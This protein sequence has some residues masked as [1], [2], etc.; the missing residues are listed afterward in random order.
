ML[1]SR[2]RSPISP[3]EGAQ[4]SNLRWRP[5]GLGMMGLQDAFSNC[6]YAFDS[7]DARKLSK[8]R[9]RSTTTRSPLRVSQRKRALIEFP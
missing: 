6:S 9:K 2:D 4:D 8:S 5:V 1:R 7:D 3:I